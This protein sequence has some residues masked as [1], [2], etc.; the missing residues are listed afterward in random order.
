MI[1]A[2]V[3]AKCV[4]KNMSGLDICGACACFAST[5]NQCLVVGGIDKLHFYAT[6]AGRF[7]VCAKRILLE[8]RSCTFDISYYIYMSSNKYR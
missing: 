7:A 3:T 8:G 5:R 6:N 1:E 4:N 2:K